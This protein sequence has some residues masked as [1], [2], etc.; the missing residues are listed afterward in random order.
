MQPGTILNV[1]SPEG[2]HNVLSWRQLNPGA[3]EF[4]LGI[5]PAGP[6]LLD[7]LSWLCFR[8][9][10]E[11]AVPLPSGLR[12]DAHAAKWPQGEGSCKLR[13]NTSPSI[14]EGNWNRNDTMASVKRFQFLFP[15]DGRRSGEEGENGFFL[16]LAICG[17]QSTAWSY[18]YILGAVGRQRTTSHSVSV[19][20]CKWAWERE[21]R[22]NLQWNWRWN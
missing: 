5:P 13:R 9:V 6:P 20:K 8:N 18:W 16:Q 21:Q 3:S 7:G 14:V 10:L 17:K 4:E 19:V 22:F 15:W 11:T 12:E 2:I 1:P